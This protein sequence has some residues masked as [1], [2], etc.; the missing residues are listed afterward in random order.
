M[1]WERLEHCYVSSEAIESSLFKRLDWFPR[2]SNKDSQ[3]LRELGD[4]LMEVLSAKAEGK[5][6]EGQMITKLNP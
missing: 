3:K 4:L 6:T 1:V 2:I 5:L